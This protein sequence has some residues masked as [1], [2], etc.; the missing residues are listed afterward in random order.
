MMKKVWLL[1]GLLAMLLVLP[2]AAKTDADELYTQQL[3]ASGAEDLFDKLPD[4]TKD[5]LYSMGV[6]DLS[7]HSTA[8][9]DVE[10]MVQS[11]WN[12]L[13]QTATSPMAAG[14]VMIGV[15]LLCAWIEGLRE[16][17]DGSQAALFGTVGVL[18]C[19]ATV[20]S[21]IVGCLDRVVQASDSASVF[22]TSFVP[23]YAG[24]L[25]TSGQWSAAASFQTVLLLASEG[26][27]YLLSRVII[28]FLIVSFALGMVGAVSESRLQLHAISE[29]LQKNTTWIL[30]ALM[31]LFIGFLS[32]QNLTAAATDSLSN[33]MLSFSISSFVPVVGGALSEA[34]GTVKG[35]LGLLKGTIGAFGVLADVLIVLPVFLE[36]VWW[37]IWLCVAKMVADMFGISSV[38]TVLK[39]SG[40]LIK[41]LMAVLACFALLMVLAITVVSK[42]GGG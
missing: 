38:G 18:T 37:Q 3:E 2:C 12:M 10:S 27:S 11:L 32:M 42:T 39:V 13:S 41:T 14:S 23:V 9:I 30:G 34:V 5:W 19:S 24:V 35:C 40:H 21:P 1:L 4:T 33:K 29:F 36:C 16:T 25:A 17:A 28:P 15:I 6:T 8:T 31:T 7:E 26:L 20:V 22:M